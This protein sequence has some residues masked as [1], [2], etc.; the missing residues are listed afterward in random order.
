[1][2]N[3][4]NGRD[5]ASQKFLLAIA[6]LATVVCAACSG[7]KILQVL[8]ENTPTTAPVPDATYTDAATIEPSKTATATETADIS[9]GEFVCE[10][11]SPSGIFSCY[12]DLIKSF[13]VLGGNGINVGVSSEKAMIIS[14]ESSCPNPFCYA[15]DANGTIW[16]APTPERIKSL[17]DNNIPYAIVLDPLYQQPRSA[18]YSML[19]RYPELVEKLGFRGVDI[20]FEEVPT[21]NRQY[22]IELENQDISTISLTVLPPKGQYFILMNY[23]QEAFDDITE[24]LAMHPNGIA[25]FYIGTKDAIEELMKKYPRVTPTP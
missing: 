14:D 8:S 9:S 3:L 5:P 19:T 25:Q 17:Q 4:S 23:P 21:T 2:K 22:Y 1:M 6:I 18:F 12:M 16:V 13:E 15:M 7:P 24:A 20:K 10:S 11:K